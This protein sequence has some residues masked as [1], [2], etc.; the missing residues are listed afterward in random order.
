LFGRE[1]FQVE[2]SYQRLDRDTGPMIRT[3]K[4]YEITQQRLKENRSAIV[5]TRMY[6]QAE[7]FSS[8]EVETL[9]QSLHA[10]KRQLLDDVE[11]ERRTIAAQEFATCDTVACND[12]PPGRRRSQ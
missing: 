11:A 2:I 4:E 1:I 12:R 9:L 3:N 10:I 7:G 5:E 6:L 8:D